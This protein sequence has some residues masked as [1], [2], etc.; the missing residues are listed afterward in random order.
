M[1]DSPVSFTKAK[2]KSVSGKVNKNL[3]P[4]ADKIAKIIN[5][6]IVSNL[7]LFDILFGEIFSHHF[8]K[9]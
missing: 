5:T 8:N 7:T 9:K 6:N 3:P 4:I 2:L 1:I